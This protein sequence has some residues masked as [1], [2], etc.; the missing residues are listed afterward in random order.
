VRVL[1]TRPLYPAMKAC[2]FFMA[3]NCKFNDDDC[4]FSH[5]HIVLFSEL[6]PYQEPD[7]E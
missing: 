4:K 6:Q 5:G 7:Y 3:G 1:F 2:D